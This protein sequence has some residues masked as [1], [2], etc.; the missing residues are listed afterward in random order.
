[1]LATAG[2]L[3]MQAYR[4]VKL[5]ALVA[6]RQFAGKIVSLFRKETCNCYDWHK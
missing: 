3:S 4:P 1:M 6:N 2:G 5:G